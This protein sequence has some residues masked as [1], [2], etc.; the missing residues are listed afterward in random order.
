MDKEYIKAKEILKKYNQ[1]H[2]LNFYEE[3]DD[4]QKEKL[5]NQILDID[6]EKLSKKITP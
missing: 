4:E 3:L 2:I 6:F 5:I 1:E